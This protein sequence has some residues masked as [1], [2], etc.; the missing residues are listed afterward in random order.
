MSE[1]VTSPAVDVLCS[2]AT[3]PAAALK[4]T[5]QCTCAD[6]C[7]ALCLQDQELQ[8][9]NF[10][11]G[12]ELSESQ[13]RHLRS[14]QMDGQQDMSEEALRDMRERNVAKLLREIAKHVGTGFSMLDVGSGTG[15]LANHCAENIGTQSLKCYD[16]TPPAENTASVAAIAAKKQAAEVHLF[17]GTNLP[18]GDQSFDLVS[19]I[20]V[21]HHAGPKYQV[22]LLKDMIRVS[23][24][25][26]VVTEDLN[27]PAFVERNEMHDISGL[28]RTN[29][30]WL[31]LWEELG[32]EVVAADL[33]NGEGTPQ[34]YYLLRKS[35]TP[36]VYAN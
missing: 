25:W 14:M 9:A 27:E 12:A 5:F 35:S 29:K 34:H 36:E 32:L 21:L 6:K 28:F 11:A 3:A 31:A 30:E 2:P 17:D 18:E 13:R 26:V 16:I 15:D 23:K 7:T 24:Q 10:G 20:F 22:P 1:E 33:C 19:A 8:A 4:F